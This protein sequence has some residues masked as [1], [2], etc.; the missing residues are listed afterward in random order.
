MCPTSWQMAP[1][2]DVDRDGQSK[3]KRVYWTVGWFNNCTPFDML[4]WCFSTEREVANHE[5][6]L[7]LMGKSINKY[8]TMCSFVNPTKTVLFRLLLCIIVSALYFLLWINCASCVWWVLFE[9]NL[10]ILSI[11]DLSAS[12]YETD[13]VIEGIIPFLVFAITVFIIAFWAAFRAKIKVPNI[14]KLDRFKIHWYD[15]SNS[16]EEEIMQQTVKF[17]SF[18]NSRHG[19]PSESEML[20]EIEASTTTAKEFINAREAVFRKRYCFNVL[21]TNYV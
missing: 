16:T 7:N 5:A 2:L 18:M 8:H 20:K 4:S 13:C 3:A 19:D 12:K 10:P 9:D 6:E 17:T 11:Y 1:M 14:S 21:Y 15:F